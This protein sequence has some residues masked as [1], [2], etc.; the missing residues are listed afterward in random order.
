[1]PKISNFK[2]GCRRKS[3]FLTTRTWSEASN[4]SKN[5]SFKIAIKSLEP[6]GLVPAKL[7]RNLKET[8][9][10]KSEIKWKSLEII[11]TKETIF[12]IMRLRSKRNDRIKVGKLTIC[13]I[14]WVKRIVRSSLTSMNSNKVIYRSR[15][16]LMRR[17]VF[18]IAFI[19]LLRP[20]RNC[21]KPSIQVIS[22]TR[23]YC[24]MPNIM[25][26]QDISSKLE[27]ISFSL[28]RLGNP[29]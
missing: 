4:R 11:S 5:K 27:L 2:K 21:N 25:T 15:N 29:R 8:P 23:I 18:W 26:S 20:S 14:Q 24:S 13:F 9:G 19:R 17:R 1:M 22:T 7:E 28:K 10:T 12:T 3:R 16:W 6:D